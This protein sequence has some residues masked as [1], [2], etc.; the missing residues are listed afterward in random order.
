MERIALET[1]DGVRLVG[2]FEPVAEA[3]GAALLLHMMP[4]TKESWAP[5]QRLLAEK[6]I[7]SLAIDLRGHG[8]SLGGPEGFRAFTDAEHQ[9]SRA[10]VAA[11]ADW[12]RERTGL[13][14]GR[15]ALVGASIGANLALEYAAAHPAVPAVVALSPGLVYHGIAAMP[16]AN[17]LA[18][19]QRVI[20]AASDDDAYSADSV[21]KLAERTLAKAEVIRFAAA[22]HGTAMFEADP[23][24]LGRVADWLAAALP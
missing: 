3:R 18:R 24:L 22:G 10:D 13:G 8:E 14:V 4:A 6:R 7:A 21:L 1:S 19:P 2:S 12:L 11:A 5:L 15:L 9:A 16:A 23:T 20:L 17:G